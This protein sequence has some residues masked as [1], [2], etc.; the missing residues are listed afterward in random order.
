MLKLAQAVETGVTAQPVNTQFGLV[1]VEN[2]ESG[3]QLGTKTAAMISLSIFKI[4]LFPIAGIFLFVF[5]CIALYGAIVRKDLKEGRALWL[6]LLLL[7]GP[8]GLV[9]YF[10]VEDRKKLGWATVVIMSVVFL[11]PFLL[12]LF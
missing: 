12:F 1:A 3:I 8:I 7:V 2:T 6:V 11:L 9:A 4:A 10:F 5:W